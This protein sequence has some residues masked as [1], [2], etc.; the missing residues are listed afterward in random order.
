MLNLI[1]N[2]MKITV[3]TADEDIAYERSC[4]RAEIHNNS[5]ENVLRLFDEHRDNRFVIRLNGRLFRRGDRTTRENIL[6]TYPRDCQ[7][8]IKHHSFFGGRRMHFYEIYVSRIEL[9]KPCRELEI[10]F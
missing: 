7:F 3:I 5:I 10:F 8:S 9:A 6:N 1:C 4:V 2:V